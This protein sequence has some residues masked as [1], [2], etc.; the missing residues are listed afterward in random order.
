MSIF[1]ANIEEQQYP[2][3]PVTNINVVYTSGSLQGS[4]HWLP[5][6]TVCTITADIP[7]PNGSFMT[8]IEKV[9]NATEVVSDIRRP[10]EIVDGVMTLEVRFKETGNF[11]LGSERLNRGLSIIGAPFR[12]SDFKIEFDVYDLL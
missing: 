11:L 4:I 2:I 3:V 10:A 12:L 7:L 9:V 6:D 1:S 5:N 8:M